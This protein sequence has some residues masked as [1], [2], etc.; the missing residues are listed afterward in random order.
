MGVEA[1]SKASGFP[2]INLQASAPICSLKHVTQRRQAQSVEKS[3][4]FGVDYRF[5]SAGGVEGEDDPAGCTQAVE[6][7][8]GFAE[9]VG[10]Q[11]DALLLQ[12]IVQVWIES[13]LTDIAGA[14]GKGVRPHAND[15]LQFFCRQPVPSFCHQRYSMNTN[16][17]SS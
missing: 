17:H 14:D 12:S 1:S 3:P 5:T 2:S 15:V 16:H 10:D 11:A 6:L 13:Q 4:T 8:G 7:F 9:R